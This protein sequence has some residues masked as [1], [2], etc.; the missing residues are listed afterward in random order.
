MEKVAKGWLIIL[1]SLKISVQNY[2]LNLT[3]HSDSAKKE[4]IV[5]KIDIND[6][7]LAGKPLQAFGVWEFYQKTFFIYAGIKKEHEFLKPGSSIYF[8]HT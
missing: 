3:F 5:D 1:I 4:P 2:T 7:L 8:H 6:I